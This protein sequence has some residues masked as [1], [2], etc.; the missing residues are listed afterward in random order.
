MVVQTQKLKPEKICTYYRLEKYGIVTIISKLHRQGLTTYE[1]LDSSPLFPKYSI[2]LYCEL[3]TQSGNVS[4]CRSRNQF[5]C[6]LG[7][8]TT[9][10][11]NNN[12]ATAVAPNKWIQM[13]LIQQQQQ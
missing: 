11:V 12:I 3:K 8:L 10:F 5:F 9:V 6:C 2:L 7:F 13:D 1:R 4:F